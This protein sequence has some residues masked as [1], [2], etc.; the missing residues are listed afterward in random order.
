MFIGDI[1]SFHEKNPEQKIVKNIKK[2][3]S[4]QFLLMVKLFL[5]FSSERKI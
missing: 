1:N 3:E 5:K 4:S 2:N